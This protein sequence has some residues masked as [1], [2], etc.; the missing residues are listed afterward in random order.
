ME[1]VPLGRPQQRGHAGGRLCDVCFLPRLSEVVRPPAQQSRQGNGC[2][3]PLRTCQSIA[4]HLRLLGLRKAM[5]TGSL[6]T[7]AWPP[8]T[9]EGWWGWHHGQRCSDPTR[10]KA[11]CAV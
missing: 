5:K 8:I 6:P 9:G 10:G 11:P 4:L 1:L 2:Q 7:D 3:R